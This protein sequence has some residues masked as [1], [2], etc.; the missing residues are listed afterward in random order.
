MST[1]CAELWTACP[2]A[3]RR[4]EAGAAAKGIRPR[5]PGDL[6]AGEG[7]GAVAPL[8]ALGEGSTGRS[9]SET[10]LRA[11]RAT[12]RRASRRAPEVRPPAFAARGFDG[13]A[14]IRRC[15]P[16]PSPFHSPPPPLRRPGVKEGQ[17]SLQNFLGIGWTPHTIP[18]ILAG[19][20]FPARGEVVKSKPLWRA[21]ID[22]G[23]YRLS[24]Y[25]FARGPGKAGSIL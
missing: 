15:V 5:R 11:S 9:I 4:E 7:L 23:H 13:A 2:M 20:V 16:T 14:E 21:G 17:S 19:P 12:A 10:V 24:R 3:I 1:L 25:L 22:T 8:T 18:S 6:S